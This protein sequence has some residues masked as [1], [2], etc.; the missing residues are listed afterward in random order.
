[1]NIEF[2]GQGFDP[3]KNKPLGYRLIHALESDEFNEFI[4]FS[5][6]VS[7]SG[8]INLR[9]AIIDF[10]NKG[11]SVNLFL[12][13]DLHGTSKEALEMLIADNIPTTIIYSPNAIV[14]HPK[15]YLLRGNTSHLIVVGSSNLTGSGLFQN[16]ESS[17]CVSF[18]YEDTQGLELEESILNYFDS[19]ISSNCESATP[20]SSELLDIL[21]KSNLVLPEATNR[22][23]QN[24]LNKLL[25]KVSCRYNDGVKSKFKKLELTRPPKGFKGVFK[26]D[27]ISVTST[28]AESKTLPTVVCENFVIEGNAMWIESGKMTGGSRN[29]LD[30]SKQG[31]QDGVV[32]QGSVE[33]FGIDK[34]AIKKDYT[35]VKD[36]TIVYDGIEYYNN[37]IKY[38]K[39]NSNWRIQ[40]KGISNSNDK[41]TDIL[42]LAGSQNRIFIFEKTD[43]VDVYK[44]HILDRDDINRLKDISVVWA[45]GGRTGKGRLYGIING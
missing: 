19:L 34:D 28:P 43:K 37:T 4:C 45:H 22:Y 1:M 42:R 36:I 2:L 20:L 5:A 25:P 17:L 13:V 16:I 29:I 24:K 12:G 27:I 18:Q 15:I 21:V 26:K 11:N 41:F 14:Y 39:G 40:L 35:K 44:F 9:D 38:T 10:I 3:T 8:V 7:S 30:L 32:R 31:R 23:A 33:F 6:F